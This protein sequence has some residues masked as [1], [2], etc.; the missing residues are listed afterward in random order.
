VLEQEVAFC[1]SCGYHI[2]G[3]AAPSLPAG[4]APANGQSSPLMYAFAL[5]WFILAVAGLLWLFARAWV[6]E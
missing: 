1:E 3:S 2:G 5:F 4:G 6:L